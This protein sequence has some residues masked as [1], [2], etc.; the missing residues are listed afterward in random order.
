MLA[1][2][3]QGH[4]QAGQVRPLITERVDESRVITLAGNLR[5]EATAENDRGPV[6][7]STPMEHMLLQLQRTPEQEQALT[8]LIEQ[9]H[10]PAS[11]NF[12]HWLTPQ[13]FGKRFGPAPEDAATITAWLESHGL[14]V[15]VIY[16]SGMLI[17]F[18][19]TV[20]QVRQA[21]H[22]PIHQLEV[23]GVPHIANISSPQ[24]PAALAPAVLGVVSLH[25]FRPHT[26]HTPRPE[27]TFTS[28][29]LTTQA[30][31]PADLATI[32]NL[33]PL[34]NAG[35]SGQGQ[36]LVVI[37]DSDLFNAADWSTFRSTFGLSGFTSGSLTQV[38]PAPPGGS[39]NC[40]DP[41]VTPTRT[42][43]SWMRNTPAQ[44]RPAPPF[45]W[46]RATAPPRLAG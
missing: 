2:L 23:K 42:K 21:F 19:G 35:I 11:P 7:D 29:G 25:D 12:H 30:V 27:Y 8:E 20:A 45:K 33:N 41:G 44:P 1:L 14:T 28:G 15:N 26:M 5:P 34:F 18:S 37:E 17:D 6:A 24:I 32:Y 46:R 31:V 40:S 22:T 10:T 16:P 3:A 9:L 4:G 43:R 39:N 13:E 36:T 38:H